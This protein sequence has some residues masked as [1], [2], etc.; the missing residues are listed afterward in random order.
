M[1]AGV[2]GLDGLDGLEKRVPYAREAS[3]SDRR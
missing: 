3:S 1:T 2:D